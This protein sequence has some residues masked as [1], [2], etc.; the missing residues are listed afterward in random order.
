MLHADSPVTVAGVPGAA[1]GF[2]FHGDAASFVDELGLDFGAVLPDGSFTVTLA[3]DGGSIDTSGTHSPASALAVACLALL[4]SALISR[5]V[6]GGRRQVISA[7]VAAVSVPA[8][9]FA[10]PVLFCSRGTLV[11]TYPPG[12]LITVRGLSM[13]TCS[14]LTASPAAVQAP[15]LSKGLKYLNTFWQASPWVGDLDMDPNCT[16]NCNEVIACSYK[17]FV[18]DSGMNKISQGTEQDG[19]LDTGSKRVMAP[20][21]VA[22]LDGNGKMDL[23][24]ASSLNLYCWEWDSATRK[25]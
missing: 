20:H 9:V 24:A 3:N 19:A 23:C 8:V 7:A 12:A 11:I 4:A 15:V 25:F 16:A 17:C 21:V 14:A 13:P 2:V 1:W 10:A 22:D 6:V 18:F 5:L